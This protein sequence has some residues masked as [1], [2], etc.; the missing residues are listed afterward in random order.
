MLFP[1]GKSTLLRDVH[2]SEVLDTVDTGYVRLTAEGNGLTDHYVLYDKKEFVG[3]VCEFPDERRLYGK[4]ALDYI[5]SL[6]SNVLAETV[7]YSESVVEKIKKEHP[8]IFL[9]PESTEKFKV[10][11][12]VF[13]GSLRAFKRGELL[14]VICQLESEGLTGCLRVS[15]ETE[16]A[17]QEGAVLFLKTP[18]AALLESEDSL[19]LGDDALRELALAFTQGKVYNLDKAFIEKFLFLN[20]AS[21]LKS[22]V[23]EIIASEKAADDLKRSM[24]LQTLG[25]ER[26]TLV[27]N[28]PCNGTFS[29]GALLKSASSR[30]FDGYLWVRSDSSRGLMVMGEGRVQ[31]AYS[32]DGERELKGVEALRR[33]YETMEF[34]G[35]VDFYQ[36]SSSPRIMQPLEAEDVTDDFLVK[37]LMGEMGQDLVK[38]ITLAKEFKKGWKSKK[39]Q[40]GD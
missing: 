9:T 18:V 34:K 7:L 19:R 33:I 22:P 8:E 4:E 10:A 16:E 15:R 35:T 29:F 36:L 28:A 31:A 25:L 39:N 32:V 26:G 1:A 11:D 3:A 5:L 40:L 24:V 20:N 38:D 21:R 14:P 23:E 2:P 27:L 12:T 6:D 13:T 17:I 37:K 30:K